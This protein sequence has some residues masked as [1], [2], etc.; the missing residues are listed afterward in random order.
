MNKLYIVQLPSGEIL[1]VWAS[2]KKEAIDY[3]KSFEKG[4]VTARL[5]KYSTI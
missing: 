1:Q 2:D 5:V 4:K 3:G